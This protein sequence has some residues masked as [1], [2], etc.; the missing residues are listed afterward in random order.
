MCT[1]GI[2]KKKLGIGSKIKK[3]NIFCKD[4]D[5]F[6]VNHSVMLKSHDFRNALL[7][8]QLGGFKKGKITTKDKVSIFGRIYLHVYGSIKIKMEC[9]YLV[10]ESDKKNWVFRDEVIYDCGRFSKKEECERLVNNINS[11]LAN[12]KF[13]FD[14]N[15]GNSYCCSKCT[16]LKI[17]EKRKERCF[18]GQYICE[19]CEYEARQKQLKMLK[20]K[21]KAEEKQRKRNEKRDRVNNLYVIYNPDSKFY[22]IGVSNDPETRLQ[23]ICHSTGSDCEILKLFPELHIVETPLHNLLCEHRKRGEWFTKNETIDNLVAQ[24]LPYLLEL[25]EKHKLLPLPKEGIEPEEPVLN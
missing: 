16:N 21:S 22:K 2:E 11:L 15:F 4:C 24:G 5:S 12:Y 14:V 10:N 7:E 25:I 9:Y 1:L 18:N 6:K 13:G 8:S 19:A 23:A 17:E 3:M 20:I